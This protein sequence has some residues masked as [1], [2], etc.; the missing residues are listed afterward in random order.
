MSEQASGSPCCVVTGFGRSGTSLVAALL[1]AA[2]LDIGSNLLGRGEGNPLGHFEDLDVL[3]FH[4]RFLAS[5]NLNTDGFTCGT[6]GSPSAELDAEAHAFVEA[7]Q[8]SGQAWGWKE[9]RTTLFLDFWKKH[10]PHLNFIFLFRYPWEVFDSLLR[11]GDAIFRNDPSLA[12]AAWIHYNKLL[13][14]YCERHE[15]SCLLLEA[16]AA[17]ANPGA[18]IAAVR[19]KFGIQLGQPADLYDK[20]LMG[21]LPSS[22]QRRLFC[23]AFP[24]A[25][26][27]FGRLRERAALVLEVDPLEGGGDQGWIEGALQFWVEYRYAAKQCKRSDAEIKP[28]RSQ[29]ETLQVELPRKEARIAQ[30]GHELGEA[31]MAL[32]RSTQEADLLRH[33]LHQH[34]IRLDSILNSR[35]WKSLGAFRS[36]ARS[37]LLPFR[38]RKKDRTLG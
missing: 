9:P 25:V 8:K 4:Q 29:L 6:P 38:G 23:Q 31:S 36:L 16:R 21:D 3:D 15:N 17:A 32:E 19:D 28:L 12:V 33:E 5:Q 14:D 34:K 11:R 1:Q 37:V 26:Q 30:L 2:G 10:I 20:D 27:L 22:A 18:V 24:E 35:A 7:R 13:L